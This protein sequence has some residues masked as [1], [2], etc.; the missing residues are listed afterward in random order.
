MKKIVTC[1]LSV[2]LSLAVA[3]PTALADRRAGPSG[4]GGSGGTIVYAPQVFIDLDGFDWA[5]DAITQFVQSGI[6]Q[7]VGDGRFAPDELVTR[8]QFAKMLTLTY[9]ASADITPTPTFADVGRDRWSY[10]YIEACSNYLTAYPNPTGGKLFFRPNEA[11]TREDIAVALVKMMGLSERDVK[12]PDYLENTFTD[13]ATVSPGLRDFITVAAEYGLLTGY[14]DGTFRPQRGITRAEAV[15][16][17]SRS[18]KIAVDAD[19]GKIP[20]DTEPEYDDSLELVASVI[21]GSRGGDVT[22]YVEA[23]QGTRVTVDGHEIIMSQTKPGYVGGSYLH[24]FPEED[25]KLFDIT[26]KKGNKTRTIQVLASYQIDGPFLTVSECPETTEEAYVTIKGYVYDKKDPEPS[27]LVNDK[28][29]SIDDDGRW[30]AR[31]KLDEEGTQTIR[32]VAG[33]HM[34]KETVLT[35]EITCTTPTPTLTVTKCRTEVER[36]VVEIAGKV[37]DPFQSMTVTVNGLPAKRDGSHWG[38]IVDLHEGENTIVV[39]AT[40]STGKSVTEERTVTYVPAEEEEEDDRDDESAR[41]EHINLQWTEIEYDPQNCRFIINGTADKVEGSYPTV[42]VNGIKADFINGNA[43][44]A[45]YP[46]EEWLPGEYAFDIVATAKNGQTQKK[47]KTVRIRPEDIPTLDP[48]DEPEDE[49][50]DTP[51]DAAEPP[52]VELITP[53]Q[54][55][56]D[57]TELSSA[58][59]ITPDNT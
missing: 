18:T 27:V 6:V 20:V 1:A 15:V 40:N 35:R 32:I 34:G 26:G 46:V 41:P 17:L 59:R 24:Y 10:P 8:E 9:G 56:E 11:A 57:K 54:N 29:A 44:R 38:R 37:N 50:D 25:S 55:A 28:P 16:L 43:W 39:T 45:I 21:Q 4:K 14:T 19:S 42:T 48:D 49:T 2:L 52:L 47:Y 51:D 30:T 36:P 13:A 31:V 22:I 58:E 33:N 3:A 7:G 12:D 5:A 53:E 23:E